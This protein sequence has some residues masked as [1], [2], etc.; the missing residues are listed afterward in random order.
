MKQFA[1]SIQML[2]ASLAT[3]RRPGRGRLVGDRAT[4]PDDLDVVM[5]TEEEV[6]VRPQACLA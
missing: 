4:C 2:L 3:D 1:R 6:V 5:T